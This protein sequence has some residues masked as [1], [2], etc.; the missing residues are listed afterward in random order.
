LGE[1]QQDIA[2]RAKNLL[3]VTDETVLKSRHLYNSLYPQMLND[4]GL[5]DTLLWHASNY[6]QITGIRIIVDGIIEEYMLDAKTK[7]ALYRAVQE[8]LTNVLRYAKAKQVGIELYEADGLIH[9]HIRD[10][11]IGFD[12]DKVNKTMHHGL[13]GMVERFIALGGDCTIASTPG[14][15]THI[16]ISVPA[17]VKAAE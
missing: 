12:P 9:L 10:N 3:K 7:L 8:S 13:T 14:K 5:M 16:A 4:S 15:G 11:G 1:G 6:Q 17:L 2:E